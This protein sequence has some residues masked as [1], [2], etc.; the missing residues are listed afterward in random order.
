MSVKLIDIL[1]S[2]KAC[3]TLGAE[4]TGK[5]TL[6]CHIIQE[7]LSTDDLVVVFSGDDEPWVEKHLSKICSETDRPYK[8]FRLPIDLNQVQRLFSRTDAE[9]Y[10]HFREMKALGGVVQFVCDGPIWNHDVGAV[11]QY[12]LTRLP[13]FSLLVQHHP[14]QTRRIVVHL[15]RFPHV[16][17]TVHLDDERFKFM[18]YECNIDC[19][20]Q[21][22]SLDAWCAKNDALVLRTS[23]PFMGKTESISGN[24]LQRP[25]LLSLGVGILISENEVKE[26]IKFE[27][28]NRL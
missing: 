23:Q 10:M 13:I 15:D 4:G 3:L 27:P 21:Y 28:I 19:V 6:L 25:D 1:D 5:T 8:N 2:N 7:R 9:I 24:F 18:L 16:F 14:M 17:P 26:L 12:M 11:W 22:S 20:D